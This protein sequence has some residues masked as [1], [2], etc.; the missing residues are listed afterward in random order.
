MLLLQF[1]IIQIGKLKVFYCPGY[2]VKVM[3]IEEN[4]FKQEKPYKGK[5]RGQKYIPVK[6]SV[7]TFTLVVIHNRIKEM[8]I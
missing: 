6:C 4:E 8:S 2:G 5:H 3:G 7:K 1:G